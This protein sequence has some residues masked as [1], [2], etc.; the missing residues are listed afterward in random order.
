LAT[1][2]ANKIINNTEIMEQTVRCL[3]LPFQSR[4]MV[5]SKSTNFAGMC[6]DKRED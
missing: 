3:N 1:D 6:T 4:E 5:T 2:L